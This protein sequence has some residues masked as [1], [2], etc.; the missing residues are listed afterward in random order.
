ML[1]IIGPAFRGTHRKLRSKLSRQFRKIAMR[2]SGPV[3]GAHYGFEPLLVLEPENEKQISEVLKSCWQEQVHVLPAGSMQHLSPIATPTHPVVILSMSRLNEPVS[4]V[5]ETIT[6]QSGMSMHT[7]SALAAGHNRHLPIEITGD[8]SMTV[9]CAVASDSFGMRSSMHGS[10]RDYVVDCTSVLA[11]GTVVPSCARS[12][13]LFGTCLRDLLVGSHG[14]LGVITQVTLRLTPLPE[15]FRICMLFVESSYEC[16]YA[17]DVLMRGACQPSVLE[18][19]NAQAAE[20]FDYQLAPEQQLLFAGFEGDAAAVEEQLQLME[21]MFGSKVLMLDDEESL[22]EFEE[23]RSWE[24]ANCG[25]AFEA[26]ISRSRSGELLEYLNARNVAA[27]AHHRLG[28]IKAFGHGPIRDDLTEAIQKL[29]GPDANIY[30]TRCPQTED[31]SILP[32]TV[33]RLAWLGKV[34]ENIDPKGI[35]PMPRQ[36]LHLPTLHR[37]ETAN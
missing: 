17:V 29:G 24:V 8:T 6:V 20:D 13:L 26:S 11:D 22:E 28:V 36:F 34:K 3:G 5:K 7:L 21:R 33:N 35:F 31:P 19:L 15:D 16:D 32:A 12:A 25:F 1:N 14:A 18:V 23:L 2:P 4:A 30:F 27:V 9:G 10:I 37:F